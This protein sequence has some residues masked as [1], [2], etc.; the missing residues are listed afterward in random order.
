MQKNLRIHKKFSF[1][2]LSYYFLFGDIW[3]IML[4]TFIEY[5][6]GKIDLNISILKG[7]I[8]IIISGLYFYSLLIKKTFCT[9][10]FT[11]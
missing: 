9:V 8:L 4:N 6:F 7:F 5:Y 3:I 2:A 10:N 1:Y 11:K